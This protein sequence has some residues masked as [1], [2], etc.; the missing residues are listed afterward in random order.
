LVALSSAEVLPETGFVSLYT[1]FVSRPAAILCL[2]SISFDCSSPFFRDESCF[3]DV[4]ILL[5]ACPSLHRCRNGP[6]GVQYLQ[7]LTHLAIRFGFSMI[8][9]LQAVIVMEPMYL[10]Q[11]VADFI[12]FL[13]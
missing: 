1:A 11:P 3:A 8:S 12:T 9:G 10:L 4:S 13:I 7:E 6:R 5:S 2:I